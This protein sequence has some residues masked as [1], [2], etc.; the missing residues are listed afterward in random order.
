MAYNDLLLPPLPP[1]P[2]EWR[3]QR[4]R[5]WR[6]ADSLWCFTAWFALTIAF[7]RLID[8]LNLPL[9]GR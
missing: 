3:R 7:I 1:S 4:R 8:L 2:Q 9:P 5:R 6:R